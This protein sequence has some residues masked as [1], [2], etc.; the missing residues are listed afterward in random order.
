MTTNEIANRL[1]ELCSNGNW[2]QAQEELYGPNIE[3][4][5]PAGTP[6]QSVKGYEAVKRKGEQWGAMMEE[7]YGNE[8][9]APLTAENFFAVRMVSDVKMKDIGRIS[10][11]ELAVYEVKDGK[12]V[13]EQFFYTP[14]KP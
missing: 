11:E 12:I 4:I 1:V 14:G 13:K 9:S 10:F 2:Q 7:F 3:S 5:E 6:W 8:I